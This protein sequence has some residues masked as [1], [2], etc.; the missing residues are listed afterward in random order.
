MYHMS[1]STIISLRTNHMFY[2]IDTII[3]VVLY[4]SFHVQNSLYYCIIGNIKKLFLQ[5]CKIDFFKYL[6][7][8]YKMLQ[9]Q[10]ISISII[11]VFSTKFVF[12]FLT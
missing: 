6:I 4:I 12:R 10:D 3:N 2:L 7:Q 1:R 5:G 9:K 11:S 8:V